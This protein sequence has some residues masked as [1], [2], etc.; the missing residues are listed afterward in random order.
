M[1]KYA[2]AYD[3]HKEQLGKPVQAQEKELTDLLSDPANLQDSRIIDYLEK[4]ISLMPTK[5]EMNRKKPLLNC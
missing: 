5:N 1:E 4:N 2:I 3:E